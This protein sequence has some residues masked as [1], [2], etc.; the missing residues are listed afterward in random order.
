MSPHRPILSA[1]TA[2]RSSALA[3]TLA[4]LLG[5]CAY[6]YTQRTDR[7]AFS[8]GNAVKANLEAQ[9]VNPSKASMKMTGGLGKNGAIAPPPATP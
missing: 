8:A 7:V 5:G 1:S 2:A 3:I 4:L 6:D 9:T